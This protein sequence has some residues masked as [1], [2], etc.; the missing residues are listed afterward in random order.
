LSSFSSNDI[1]R[2]TV[3]NDDRK[4]WIG[5][6]LYA[7]EA[8]SGLSIC[9]P[10]DRVGQFISAERTFQEV[11]HHENS[12]HSSEYKVKQEEPMLKDRLVSCS[13]KLFLIVL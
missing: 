2:T 11:E 3:N 13:K 7:A 4:Y 10:V 1:S 8:V 6:Q 5:I 9:H 12:F